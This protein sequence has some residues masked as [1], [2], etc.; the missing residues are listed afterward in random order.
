MR[1]DSPVRAPQ[2]NL[3][4]QLDA[5]SRLRYTDRLTPADEQRAQLTP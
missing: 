5:R 3:V 1:C 2:T 4:V